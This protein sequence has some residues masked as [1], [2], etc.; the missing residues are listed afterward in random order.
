M[1]IGKEFF[2]IHILK[3]VF[4]NSASL[5]KDGNSMTIHCHRTEKKNSVAF[6]T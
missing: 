1:D 6:Q 5:L 3:R 4:N 2:C